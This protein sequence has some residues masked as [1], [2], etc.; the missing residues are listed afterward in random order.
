[1]GERLR[2]LLRLIKVEHTLF[3]LPFLYSGAVLAQGG[4]PEL[5]VL[6]WITVGLFSARTAGMCLNRLIDREIDA[7]NPRTAHRAE[8]LGFLSLRFVW[9]VVVA[10]L[11]LLLL[12]ALMLNPLCVLLFPLVAALLLVYPYTKRFTW[13]SHIVLGSALG[14]APL[15]AWAA[16]RGS[17]DLPAL[18]LFAAVMFWVAGFDVIYALQDVEFDRRHGLKSIPARFGKA[19]A[20]NASALFHLLTLASLVLLL[21]FSE[22]GAVY[23]VGLGVMAAVLACEHVLARRQSIGAAFFQANAVFSALFLIFILLSL[24]LR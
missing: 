11:A 9:G 17:I 20:L 19:A 13:L 14:M 12:S 8:M 23:A 7:L 16:V 2:V 18:L 15:G 22:L 24:A 10:S 5:S 21:H 1:M 4:I 3:A 6:L